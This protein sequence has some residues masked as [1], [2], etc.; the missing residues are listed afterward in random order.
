MIGDQRSVDTLMS[1]LRSGD[2]HKRRVAA[3]AL[4][5]TRDPRAIPSL[6]KTLADAEKNVRSA[7]AEALGYIGDPTREILDT[8]LEWRFS[9]RPGVIGREDS[10]VV[11]SL[12]G[13]LEDSESSVRFSAARALGYVGDPDAVEA[14]ITNLGRTDSGTPAAAIALA[15]IGGLRA[16]EPL[17]AAISA[18]P[19][20]NIRLRAVEALGDL[21]A[22]A[23]TTPL[24]NALTD[25]EYEVRGAAATALAKIGDSTAFS[26]LLESQGR[27]QHFRTRKA[28]SQAMQTLHLEST[29][30]SR[31]GRATYDSP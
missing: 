11:K 22:K 12:I 25:D 2:S 18:P 7:A 5:V 30:C 13:A 3:Q 8:N 17:V 20:G 19:R 14:L 21:K 15:E 4:G 27:E 23:A 6:I 28:M 10:R 24:I 1:T 31:E 26:S 16:V 29:R 9:P